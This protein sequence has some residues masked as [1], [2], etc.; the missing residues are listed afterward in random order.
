[1]SEDENGATPPSYSRSKHKWDNFL[2]EEW[3]RH[4]KEH[5]DTMRKIE[6]VHQGISAIRQ[7]TAHLTALEPISA[8]LREMKEGLF[9]ILTGKNVVDVDTVKDLLKAQQNSYVTT[10][11]TICKIFGAVVIILVGL[12]VFVPQWFQ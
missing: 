2:E 10:I 1:M 11:S 5:S 9:N 4:R 12:K 8:T 6:E 7:N 3:P